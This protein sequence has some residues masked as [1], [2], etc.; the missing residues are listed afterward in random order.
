MQ[1]GMVAVALAVAAVVALTLAAVLSLRAAERQDDERRLE[2]AAEDVAT[3]VTTEFDRLADLAQDLAVA[4]PMVERLDAGGYEQ[5]L[6]RFE[7]ERRFP[8]LTGVSYID[9]VPRDEVAD[10]LAQREPGGPPLVLREDAGQE[11]VR[12]LTMSYPIEI[13]RAAVGVDLTS[14]AESRVAH[15][16][17]VARGVPV[18]SNLTRILQLPPEEPGVVLHSPVLDGGEVVATLGLVVSVPG[19]LSGLEPLPVNVE[20]AV[21]DPASEVFPDPVVLETG[22]RLSPLATSTAALVPG[23]GWIVTV[24]ATDA[25]TQAWLRRGSTLLAI[26]GGVAALLVGLLVMT[27]ATRQRHASE[28]V[29]L[30]T[31]ELSGANRDL[32]EANRELADANQRLASAGRDKDEFLAAVSHELRTPLTVITGFLELIR[33]LEPTGAAIG[34]MLDP[35][36]RNVRRLDV[37]VGDLLTLVSLDAGAAVSRPEP[38]ELEGFLASAPQELAGL[39]TGSVQVEVTGGPVAMADRRH[40]E[41]IVVNLLVN[42]ERHGA[43]PVVVRAVRG[44]NGSVEVSVRDHGAGLP[45]GQDEMV[46]ERFARAPGQQAVTGTGLGLAIVRELVTL[47]GGSVRYEAA[48]PGARFIVRLPAWTDASVAELAEQAAQ[49]R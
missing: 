17:A 49:A 32:A 14:R 42:A 39:S 7:L 19:F 44:T 34:E 28:L 27:L 45:S 26:G 25:F 43:P 41:R 30:R 10:R 21:A 8:A 37:L 48:S 22:E 2:Q 1:R 5:L 38:I 24:T 23:Q 35:I 40:L 46:F 29:T 6:G 3:T 11:V 33:R 18:L 47:G 36:D 20:V 9:R 12:L 13:N 4:L 31:S 16:T 15:D